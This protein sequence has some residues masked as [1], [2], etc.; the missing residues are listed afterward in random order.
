MMTLIG[1]AIFIGPPLVAI[2]WYTRR[3]VEARKALAG[4]DPPD[5][6][7]DPIKMKKA[8]TRDGWLVLGGLVVYWI[9]V[10]VLVP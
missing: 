8:V 7:R 6:T 5:S 1:L 2:V 9:L 4:E 10:S 3:L